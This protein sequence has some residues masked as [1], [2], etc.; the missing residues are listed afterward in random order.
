[1]DLWWDGGDGQKVNGML[2]AAEPFSVVFLGVG[3]QMAGPE[4]ATLAIHC[5]QRSLTQS[6]S[7]PMALLHGVYS[8]SQI[9]GIQAVS[10]ECT[11]PDTNSVC[12]QG[13]GKQTTMCDSIAGQG[14]MRRFGLV[15][16]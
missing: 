10:A 11:R 13:C 8:S 4:L 16:I 5:V 9:A 2:E 1:M 3:T 7:G 6:W 14:G 12:S 15:P